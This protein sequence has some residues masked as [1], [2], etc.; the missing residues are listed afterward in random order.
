MPRAPR[1]SS[2][3]S[4]L[5]ESSGLSSLAALRHEAERS[6]KQAEE[7]RAQAEAEQRARV[8]VERERARAAEERVQRERALQRSAE[9]T[10]LGE[11]AELE[12]VRAVESERAASEARAR[13]DL[14]ARLLEERAEQR[15]AEIT[16]L[17]R[18][19]RQR[20][21]VVLSSALCAVTWLAS[22][23]AYFGLVRPDT[24]RARLAFERSLTD[25]RQAV[26]DADDK[27]ARAMQRSASLAER[28]SSLQTALREERAA[29][30]PASSAQGT[31]GK[32]GHHGPMHG[33][34]APH[35]PCPDADDGD[36]LNPCLKR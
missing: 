10:R 26:R 22:A 19:A 1:L 2:C 33:V 3:M 32:L 8:A 12:R 13:R 27:S 20:L 15:R 30:V 21:W 23:G 5:S 7:A 31:P 14:E 35:G 34:T 11:L 29:P 18:V 17:G 24:E 9:G 16:L 28:V 6:Q 36:P 4:Q 25:E